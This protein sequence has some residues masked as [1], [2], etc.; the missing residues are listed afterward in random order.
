[1]P[2]KK[3]VEPLRISL[4]VGVVL[5]IVYVGLHY[6]MRWSRPT[7]QRKTPP[8]IE[9]VEDFYVH[10][11]KSYVT[12]LTSAQKLVGKPL[13]VIEGYRWKTQPDGRLLEPIEKIVPTAIVGRGDAAVIRFERDGR[14]ESVESGTPSRLY[15]DEMFFI[16]DPREL[17]HHWPAETWNKVENR[18][19]EIGMTEFQAAF[20]LGAGQPQRSSQRGET[21]IV[22][23]TFRKA[24]GLEAVRVTFR[25]GRA[26]EIEP[27]EQ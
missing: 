13:W 17:Y 20:A 18:E 1:V 2:E 26:A 6:A 24:A 25:A 11:P 16:Q 12:D 8:P 9:R 5:A 23:Y 10:P 3:W 22:T 15:I 4:R 27:L 21:R 19:F 7:L 14:T